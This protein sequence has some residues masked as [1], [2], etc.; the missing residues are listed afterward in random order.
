MRAC[1]A[2]NAFKS[3]MRNPSWVMNSMRERAEVRGGV[4]DLTLHRTALPTVCFG[5]QW[6]RDCLSRRF[7]TQEHYVFSQ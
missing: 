7:F 3:Q 2:P 4:R 6:A 5:N 1:Q